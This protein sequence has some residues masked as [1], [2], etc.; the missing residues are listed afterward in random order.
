MKISIIT[1]SFNAEA[2]ISDAMESVWAQE[3]PEGVEIDYIAIDGLSTDRTVEKIKAFAEKV[4]RRLR[5][6]VEGKRFSFRWVSEK[7]N[8]LYD[9]MNKGLKMATGEVVGILNADDM[10][11]ARDTIAKVAERFVADDELKFLY[12]DVR[13]V[14]QDTNLDGLKSATTKRF[15]CPIIWQP[16]MLTFGYAPPHPGM[17]VKKECFEKWGNYKYEYRI[18]ADYEMTVRFLRKQC[19]RREYLRKCTVAMRLGGASTEKGAAG[20]FVGNNYDVINANRENGY[21][22]NRW[23]ILGK[24]PM[25]ALE[26]IVPKFLRHIGA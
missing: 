11:N 26:I 21:L 8:G 23:L 20:S 3:L 14:A 19:V 13:F 9:A 12:S 25:K 18:G 7:D 1:V 24:L 4:E 17:Y 10:M 2:T 15:I 5:E 22:G 16:W 6:K